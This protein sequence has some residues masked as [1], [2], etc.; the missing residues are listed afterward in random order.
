M[1]TATAI[2]EDLTAQ[3]EQKIRHLFRQFDADHSG[4]VSENEI[5]GLLGKHGVKITPS[6]VNLLIH[7]MDTNKDGQLD[8]IEFRNLVRVATELQN[9]PSSSPPD[10]T[11]NTPASLPLEVPTSSSSSSSS[12][13][14]ESEYVNYKAILN[15]LTP[16][17]FRVD[18]LGER[19]YPLPFRTLDRVRENDRVLYQ[20]AYSDVNEINTGYAFEIAGQ[21]DK[22]YFNPAEVIVGILTAG[23]LC[24]GLN[25]V[26]RAVA[27]SC[28]KYGIKKVLGFKF[29]YYGLAAATTSYVELT[30]E[31]LTDVHLIGGSI[32]GSSRAYVPSSEVAET[33]K[34]LGVSIVLCIGGDGTQKGAAEFKKEADRIGYKIS[35]VG[36]P[37]TM[38]NDILFVARTFGF[39]TSFHTASKFIKGAHTETKGVNGGVGIVRLFGRDSGFVAAHAALASGYANIVLIPEERFTLR[40]LFAAIRKRILSPRNHCLIVVAEGAGVDILM[41]LNEA[42][43]RGVGNVNYGDIGLFLRDA[44]TRYFKAEKLDIV[45]RYFD[46]TYCIRDIPPTA[47]DA[48][49]CEELGNKAVDSALAGKTN[50]IVGFWNGRYTLVPYGMVGRGRKIIDVKGTMWSTVKAMTENLDDYEAEIA[51][52]EKV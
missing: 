34:K 41:Q 24:P 39:E 30:P 17:D 14:S 26:V 22:L 50:C 4:F 52:L 19:Q 48:Q 31:I 21:R 5:H 27:Y 28:F 46:P 42:E 15:G 49:F 25:D 45:I 3:H 47:N 29:G 40:A 8:L 33:C 6:Q 18:Q 13:S 36:I 38:D 35:V 2:S 11:V 9:P 16:D 32:L 12:S 43:Q 23:G 10:S 7:K 37:K 20:S 44:I 51:K 1:S